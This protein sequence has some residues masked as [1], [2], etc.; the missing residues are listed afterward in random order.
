MGRPPKRIELI[1]GHIT[2]AE[3]QARVNGEDKLQVKQKMRK[4]KAVKDDPVANSYYNRLVSLY[5]E[6]DMADAMTE[7]VINRYCVLLARLGDIERLGDK[8]R[9]AL[10]EMEERKD[11]L[12]YT[13]YIKQVVALAKAAVSNEK[14]VAKIRDQL[15]AIEKENLMTI[16]GKLRAVPKKPEKKE[17]KSGFAA[18][19]DRWRNS[20][21]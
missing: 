14:A 4:S 15:L 10:D 12:E 13:E 3:K 1:E 8:L 7:N 11:E 19:N 2:R 21:A 5:R 17:Q 6:I 9:N 18:Y 20:S 16:Q